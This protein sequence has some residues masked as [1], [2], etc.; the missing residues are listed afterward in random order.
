MININI[1]MAIYTYNNDI[2]RYTLTE[3]IFKHYQTIR[4]KFKNLACFTFTI[5]GSEH[6]I[7]KDLALK[8]FKEEEYFEFDQ[9]NP[10]FKDDFFTMLG[11]KINLGIHLSFKNNPNIL[12]WAGSNDY[13]C[14][15][16]FQQIIEKYNPLVPQIY[17]I[18]NYYNGNN[19]V[20]YTRFDANRYKENQMC[21]TCHNKMSY[22]WDGISDYCDRKKF[23]YCGGIIGIN[24]TA[25]KEY[26]DILSVWSYDEGAIEEYILKKSVEKFNGNQLFYINTKCVNDKDV[27]P[28]EELR[29]LNKDHIL[30]FDKKFS[31]NFKEKFIK[32]FYYFEKL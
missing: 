14:F 28:Y 31:D 20:F 26:P 1:F 23:K 25:F 21:M 32:E 24:Y 7:S 16:F 12:L 17:G 29:K 11:N 13:I 22:W 15:D 19:A 9:N 6:N 3:K 10:N 2:H 4:N 30:P 18:D 27:T 8:Y 5:L